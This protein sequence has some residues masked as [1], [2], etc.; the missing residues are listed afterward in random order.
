MKTQVFDRK[1]KL[2]EEFQRTVSRK[3]KDKLVEYTEVYYLDDSVNEDTGMIDRSK[4]EMFYTKN[5]TLRNWQSIK[6]AYLK[7]S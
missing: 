6:E 5:Q 3:F 2:V 1:G 7:A 4:S